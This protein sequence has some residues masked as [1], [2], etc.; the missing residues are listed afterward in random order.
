MEDLV[1]T[2]EEF[3]KNK[4]R[5]QNSRTGKMECTITTSQIRKFLSAV[6]QLQNKM[7]G[8]EETLKTETAGEIKY[9]K[10]KLAYQAGREK[11]TK[12]LYDNLA[13]IIDA[14]GTS[15]AKFLEFAKYIEAIVAYHKFY[16]G[17][18]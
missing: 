14:I 11:K 1:K 3:V 12:V 4:L 5:E 8:E 17:K 2:A 13:P 9:L 18:D 16:G 10:I 6:N 7:S 15:K